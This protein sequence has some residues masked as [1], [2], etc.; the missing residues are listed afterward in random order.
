MHGAVRNPMH[1]IDRVC[2]FHFADTVQ[3]GV[4]RWHLCHVM[5]YHCGVLCLV[6][7]TRREILSGMESLCCILGAQG[8]FG[9]VGRQTQKLGKNAHAGSRTRVTSMVGLYDAATLHALWQAMRNLRC[10]D[11]ILPTQAFHGSGP[12]SLRR[13]AIFLVAAWVGQSR[14]VALHVVA[15]HVSQWGVKLA[16]RKKEGQELCMGG[17][18]AVRIRQPKSKRPW[19]PGCGSFGMDVVASKM[20]STLQK[21]F[22]RGH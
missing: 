1:C 14:G 5:K 20:I 12:P 22:S 19:W 7:A 10:H 6:G 11:D 4:V 8:R 9:V 13:H 3:N 2:K 15:A 17:F 21:Q 18:N 16:E